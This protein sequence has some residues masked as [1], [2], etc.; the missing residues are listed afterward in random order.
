MST[1][2]WQK[3]RK[4]EYHDDGCVKPDPHVIQ[5]REGDQLAHC[6]GCASRW[7]VAEDEPVRAPM[8]ATSYVCRDH[9]EPVT[10]RGQ[11]CRSCRAA[12]A[13]GAR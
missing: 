3:I 13:R 11:G 4:A 6:L 8:V 12:A 9:Y 10:W 5:M 1:I 7:I 2:V